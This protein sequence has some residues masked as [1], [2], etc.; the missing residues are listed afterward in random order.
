VSGLQD[1]LASK[2][3]RLNLLIT[4]WSHVIM[5]HSPNL[6][7]ISSANT[8]LRC[9]TFCLRDNYVTISHVVRVPESVQ[10][11]CLKSICA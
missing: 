2:S 10:G 6:F 5:T 3:M 7:V 1:T 4:S 8:S 11:E 9:I